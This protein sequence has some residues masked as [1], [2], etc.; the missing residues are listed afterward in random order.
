MTPDPQRDQATADT[1]ESGT[2]TATESGDAVAK[3]ENDSPTIATDGGHETADDAEDD[4][5]ALERDL[6]VRGERFARATI[7]RREPPV[8]A[9]VGD[10]AIVTADGAVHGWIGG[11]AC[12]QSIVTREAAEVIETGTPRLIG[13]APDPETVARSGLEAFPM[14]CHSEG[15]LEVFIEPV[16]PR[17]D[18]VVV[19]DSPIAHALARLAVELPLD[20]TLVVDEADADRD[21]PAS[22]KILESLDT[23]EIAAAVGADPIVVAASMGAYDARG[24]AAGILAGAQYVGLVASDARAAEDTERAAEL[25]DRDVEEV[26][27]AVTNPAGVD[28]AA[29]TPVEIAVSLLA[30]VV[31]VDE[32]TTSDRAVAAGTEASPAT[33]ASSDRGSDEPAE[34]IDPVCGMTVPVDEAAATVEHGGQTYY[35]CCHGCADSFE[36]DPESHLG[37]ES[38]E[39]HS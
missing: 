12:A 24:I 6:R 28:I 3:A 26:T 7:V 32:G 37:D 18:L 23:E 16:V 33:G 10:R 4:L 13:I 21:V 9:N 35:F 34:A 20:V 36:A 30:E 15:V 1:T 31:D 17:R 38:A 5:S 8:S 25:L 19:G 27:S 11:A 2:A 22:T 29:H 39:V 14:M